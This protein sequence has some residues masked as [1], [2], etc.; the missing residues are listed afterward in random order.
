[1]LAAYDPWKAEDDRLREV[2]EYD[3]LEAAREEAWPAVR[4]LEREIAATPATTLE[5]FRIKAT[6]IAN[7]WFT[8][9]GTERLLSEKIASGCEIGDGMKASLLLDLANW[10]AIA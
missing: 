9:A 8:K 2:H 7:D 1:M 3:A 6:I 5:G 10:Q 4:D